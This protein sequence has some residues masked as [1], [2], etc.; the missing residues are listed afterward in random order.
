M[1]SRTMCATIVVVAAGHAASAQQISGN[2]ADGK[3]LAELWC[4]SC[5]LVSR[6]QERTTTEA[7]PFAAIAG[8]SEDEFAW[9]RAFLMD[10]HPPMPQLT[11][12]RDE[13][14]NLVAYIAS[15]RS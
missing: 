1:L 13:I 9:L 15:L 8:R 11:L 3:Q 12:T 10:P 14:R 7:P 5:H 4:S 6:E 2:A